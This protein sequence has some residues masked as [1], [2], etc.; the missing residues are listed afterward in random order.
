MSDRPKRTETEILTDERNAALREIARLRVCV[1]RS[2]GKAWR[3]ET[4]DLSGAVDTALRRYVEAAE[5]RADAWAA[6]WKKCDDE[7]RAVEGRLAAAD[8]VAKA[9]Q[10]VS[11]YAHHAPGCFAA[12][13]R[14][15]CGI[16]ALNLAL[17]ALEKP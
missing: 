9:A 14:C 7:K 8:R 6:A 17:A 5:G 2:D 1:E 16:V 13:A 12:D 3:P 10:Q 11:T 4:W 15:P